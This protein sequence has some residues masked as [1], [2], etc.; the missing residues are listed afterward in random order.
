MTNFAKRQEDGG[1]VSGSFRELFPRT[2]ASRPVD[3]ARSRGY[4]PVRSA[5]P[6]DPLVQ[7]LVRCEVHFDELDD[8]FYD[9]RV[10]PLALDAVQ[11]GVVDAIQMRLDTFARSRGYD[12]ILSACTY[13]AS[14]VEHFARE[15]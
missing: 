8:H 4:E 5:R 11:V 6:H 12:G 14:S 2:S 9:V 15:G 7:Q 3:Y 10:E 13:A 1:I